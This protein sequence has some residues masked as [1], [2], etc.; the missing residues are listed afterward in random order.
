M[1]YNTSNS[2]PIIPELFS[3]NILFTIDYSQNYSGIIEHIAIDIA[4]LYIV[5]FSFYIVYCTKESIL[6]NL[7][8]KVIFLLNAKTKSY[9]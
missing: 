9:L 6:M 7:Q 4:N 3:I 8:A 2:Y 5:S 1:L